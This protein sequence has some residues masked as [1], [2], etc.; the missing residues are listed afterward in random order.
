[1][2]AGAGGQGSAALERGHFTPLLVIS[3]SLE[4][5]Q[6]ARSQ[7]SRVGLGKATRH[8]WLPAVCDPGQIVGGLGASVSPSDSQWCLVL[9]HSSC[10]LRIIEG[11]VTD[12]GSPQTTAKALVLEVSFRADSLSARD[13]VSPPALGRNVWQGGRT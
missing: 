3:L 13:T 2:L 1:M 4:L 11:H 10:C 12:C 8:S 7:G 5:P 6:H 9:G